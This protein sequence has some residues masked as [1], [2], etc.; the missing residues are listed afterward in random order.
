MP[1]VGDEGRWLLIEARDSKFF[2]SGGSWRQS[3]DWVGYVSLSKSNVSLETALAAAQNWAEKYG[4]PTIWV[5]S[6]P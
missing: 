5:Q 3:G 4:V 2:G 6:R 1:D